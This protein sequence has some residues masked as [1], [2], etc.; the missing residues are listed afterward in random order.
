MREVAG[1]F[2]ELGPLPA[3]EWVIVA[4]SALNLD[5]EKDAGGLGRPIIDCVGADVRQQEKRGPVLFVR[6]HIGTIAEW[7]LT[8]GGQNLPRHRIP[9]TI[10]A[11]L[12]GQPRFKMHR[13]ALRPAIS[14]LGR[15]H[16]APVAGPMLGVV[17][18]REQLI[19]HLRA[20]VWIFIGGELGD[21]RGQRQAP[22]KSSMTL[23]R[24]CSSLVVGAGVILAAACSLAMSR[25]ISPVCNGVVGTPFHSSPVSRTFFS[26]LGGSAVADPAS[27]VSPRSE[28][29]ILCMAQTPNGSSIPT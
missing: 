19:D 1:Q 18:T 16:V 11:E 29:I 4:L 22:D 20:L 5:A 7:Q 24:N 27:R 12:L 17:F 25:S 21:V 14:H 15:E 2:V 26:L 9:M 3:I 23:R 8:L 13:E 6:F 28:A 10:L